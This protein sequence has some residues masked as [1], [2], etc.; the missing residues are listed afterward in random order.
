MFQSFLRQSHKK[1]NNNSKTTIPVRF[2]RRKQN[3]NKTKGDVYLL[4]SHIRMQY[5]VVPSRLQR[6]EEV[7]ADD[8]RTPGLKR[9]ELHAVP[10]GPTVSCDDALNSTAFLIDTLELTFQFFISNGRFIS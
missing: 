5:T 2:S 1:N 4:L 7:W 10:C 9:L 8:D 6:E 3:K